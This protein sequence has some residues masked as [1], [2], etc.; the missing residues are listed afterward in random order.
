MAERTP[1]RG[2]L[3]SC[4]VSQGGNQSPML[5]CCFSQKC[6]DDFELRCKNAGLD[7]FKVP[8]DIPGCAS[9]TDKRIG[10]EGEDTAPFLPAKYFGS[11]FFAKV[12]E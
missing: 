8:Y 10:M 12:Q 11:R 3:C 2:I 5:Y 4:G 7:D 6:L 9:D 1:K